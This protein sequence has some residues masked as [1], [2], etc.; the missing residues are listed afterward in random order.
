VRYQRPSV[1]VLFESVAA[2]A[3]A[4]AIGV[5]LTGMG[6]DGASGLLA[7]RRAGARTIAQ[8]EETSVVYGMPRAAVSLGAAEF[9][10]PL[11]RIPLLLRK[12]VQQMCFQES[13]ARRVA[14]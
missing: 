13:T 11:Q 10:V 3:R 7:M 1:N 14:P 5:L 12:L 8:D 2:R 4:R 6:D 9:V